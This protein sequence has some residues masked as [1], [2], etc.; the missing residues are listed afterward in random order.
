SE[1]DARGE[2]GRGSPDRA[3]TRKVRSQL[4]G[5]QRDRALE[6]LHPA[7]GA[8]PVGGWTATGRVHGRSRGLQPAHDLRRPL[9][10]RDGYLLRGPRQRPLPRTRTVTRVLLGASPCRRRPSGTRAPRRRSA[11]PAR[12]ALFW[13]G[14]LAGFGS[15]L[16]L[17]S[18]ILAPFVR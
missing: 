18:S 9:S 13:L 17:L 4:P 6:R 11:P 12:P 10:G 15:I 3:A 7:G 14:L 8:G 5:G 16:W 2:T 1:A